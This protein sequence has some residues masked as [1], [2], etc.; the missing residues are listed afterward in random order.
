MNTRAWWPLIFLGLLASPVQA[1]DLGVHGRIFTIEEKDLR[2]VMMEQLMNSDQL[3]TQDDV[4]EAVDTYFEE[5][6]RFH[7]PP[8]EGGRLRVIDPSRTLTRDVWA[9]LPDESGKMVNRLLARKGQR[10][11]PWEKGF[12][13]FTAFL[14]VDAESK[15]QVQLAKDA[16]AVHPMLI[17]VVLVNGDPRDIA[18]DVDLPIYY[19]Q[20]FMRKEFHIEHTP[21]FV[22]V[23]KVDHGGVI[24]VFE[25]DRPYTYEG[26]TQ[27][28]TEPSDATRKSEHGWVDQVRQQRPQTDEGTENEAGSR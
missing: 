16:L 20:E 14:I 2:A 8:R 3:P 26:L 17:R 22:W 1:I 19:L 24:K 6:P 9:P 15:D 4:K 23:E 27:H 11:N 10:L 28:W 21:S 13:P 12:I 18:E 25:P 7:L 5:L